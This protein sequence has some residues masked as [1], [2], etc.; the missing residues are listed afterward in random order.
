MIQAWSRSTEDEIIRCIQE[1]FS[2]K[3]YETKNFHADDRVHELGRDLVCVR[4]EEE[5]AFSVK[6]KPRKK[7]IKQLKTFVETVKNKKGIYVFIEPPTRPFEQFMKSLTTIIF[8]NASRLHE[9][10]VKGESTPYLRL[11]FSAHPV[12]DTLTKV[13]E[14]VYTKRKTSFE[15]R[16]LTTEELEKLWV[17]KDN[18][19]KMRSMLLNMYTRWAKKLMA[20]TMRKPQE[21]QEIIDEVFEDLDVVNFLCGEK[22][23]SSFEE[24]GDKHPNLF[25]L[26]WDN[27]SQRTNWKLFTV[28]I[29]KVKTENISDLIRLWWVLPK[30]D[31]SISYVMKGFYS[32]VNYILDNFH[33]VAKNLEDGIDWVFEDMKR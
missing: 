13:N 3:G 16:K 10:L 8:W 1:V 6:K 7:D 31:I 5:I 4:G 11:L 29:E 28:A 19:V 33:T 23:T 18:I 20:K 14:I 15:K 22:L 12:A 30:L 17:A 32:T 2:R 21:Y 25:G 24:I 27:V 9:E 26:F